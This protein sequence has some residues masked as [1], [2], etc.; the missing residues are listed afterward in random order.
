M[1]ADPSQQ[2]PLASE[3]GTGRQRAEALRAFS[4]CVKTAYGADVQPQGPRTEGGKQA[5]VSA[6]VVEISPAEEPRSYLVELPENLQIAERSPVMKTLLDAA[7][8]NFMACCDILVQSNSE[9]LLLYRSVFASVAYFLSSR[10]VD[11][12]QKLQH[13]SQDY[14]LRYVE[15]RFATMLP[16]TKSID[17]IAGLRLTY[18]QGFRNHLDT[19]GDL[20]HR[21]TR[22]IS[23]PTISANRLLPQKSGWIFRKRVPSL[24]KVIPE[25]NTPQHTP[26]PALNFLQGS[27]KQL[28][29][30]EHLA[31][32][33]GKQSTMPGL[34]SGNTVVD[35]RNFVMGRGW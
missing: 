4:T 12:E 27:S 2:C 31:H 3:I 35:E 22:A 6:C 30:W 11:W 17:T 1:Y 25:E 32:D 14:A 13:W 24:K 16:L 10:K 20:C 33:I 7:C 34:R 18:Q 23:V 9:I 5:T 28:E 29:I 19:L 15:S 8:T 26:E 21:T